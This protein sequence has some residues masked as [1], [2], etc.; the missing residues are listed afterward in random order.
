MKNA[1]SKISDRFQ[2]HSNAV[3]IFRDDDNNMLSFRDILLD[4]LPKEEKNWQVTKSCRDRARINL[5]C[6]QIFRKT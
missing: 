6:P 2:K 4:K 1:V 5:A 3:A